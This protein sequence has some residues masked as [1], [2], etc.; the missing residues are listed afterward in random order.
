MNNKGITIAGSFI[1]DVVKTTDCY[2]KRGM[3][4]YITDV[5]KAVGGCVP[6]TAISLKKIDSSIPVSAIGKI[7]TDEHGR[8]IKT[9]LERHGVDCNNV[10]ISESLTTSFCDVM[11]QPSGERTFFHAKGANAEFSPADLNISNLNCDIFHIGYI[12]LLDQFEKSDAQHGSVLARTLKEIQEK[13]IKTSIDVV[14]D[15][16]GKYK[17]IIIPVLRFCSYAIM[18]EVEC[19][20]L[21]DLAPYDENGRLNTDNIKKTM[22]FMAEKGVK[23]KIIIHCKNAGFCLDVKSGEFTIV[24][25]LEIPPEEIKGSVGAGDAFC[26][27]SLYGLYNNYS[28]EETL[29][30][31][32]A[33]A[34][35]N[36]FA[37]NSTDSILSKEDV[38][39]FEEKYGRKIL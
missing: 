12:F 9:E 18:N 1:A 34:A 20:M 11:S 38:W 35:S 7:G 39:A 23:E 5:K 36:L 30:L 25:S 21:T 14:S 37:E 13:G 3:M 33:I 16:S 17:E 32:S 31:A 22:V 8:F 2:P 27:G 15:S 4:A 6:N 19:C 24:P 26:A 28:D 10:K 29:K